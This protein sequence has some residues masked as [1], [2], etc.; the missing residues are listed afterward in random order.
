MA[1]MRS[2]CVRKGL[3]LW[4]LELLIGTRESKDSRVQA[5]LASPSPL[6][7]TRETRQST[8]KMTIFFSK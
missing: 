2:T 8:V 6:Q 7:R 4:V 5:G 1:G 3:I